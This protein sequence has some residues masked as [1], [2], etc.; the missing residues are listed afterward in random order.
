METPTNP[1][2]PPAPRK[3]RSKYVKPSNDDLEKRVEFTLYLIS[4]RIYK[5]QIID[6]LK[7]KYDVTPRTC[8]TYISRAREKIQEN[9]GRT[10]E[11]HRVDSIAFYESIVAAPDTTMHQKM[12]AQEKLDWIFG[13][14]HQFKQDDDDEKKKNSGGQ[15]LAIVKEVVTDRAT[16]D[17]DDRAYDDPPGGEGP[18]EDSGGSHD[19]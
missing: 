5:H 15:R 10:R 7:R 14:G 9:S 19:G 18:G 1:N 16:A 13:T 4:R 3:A 12:A 17:A 6:Q 8:E 2:D 11:E